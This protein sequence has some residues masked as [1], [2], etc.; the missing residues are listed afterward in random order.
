MSEKLSTI[1]SEIIQAAS[2]LE[3]DV[4]DLTRDEYLASSAREV[5]S[6]RQII[7]NGGWREL[8][9]LAVDA[10]DEAD[11]DETFY[12]TDEVPE[13]ETYVITWAQNA[14][15]ICPTTLGILEKYCEHNNAKL[16][17][18]PGRYK[19]TLSKDDYWWDEKLVP[20]L[21]KGRLKIGEHCVAYGDISIQPT[22][23]TPL[24]GF[25]VFAGAASAV[26]GH[27]KLQLQTVAS[28]DRMA[29]IFTTTGA[30]TKKN[31]REAKAGAKAAEHHIF[32]AAIVETDGD[33]FHLRQLVVDKNGE[34]YDLDKVYTPDGVRDAEAAAVFVPGD[35]HV[36][37]MTEENKKSLSDIIDFFEPEHMVVHDVLDF[38]VRNHHRR[39]DLID[40]IKRA[41]G[42]KC[43]LVEE[44]VLETCAYLYDLSK[45]VSKLHV[46]RSNHDE[47][48][49]RWLNETWP[50]QDPFNA[51]FWFKT[52]AAMSEE[53][54]Q[55][56]T[57]NPFEYWF[58]EW[59]WQDCSNVHFLE[60]NESLKIKNIAFNFHGDKG[61][62][63]ARGS[64]NQFSKLGT[65]SVVGHSHSPGIRDGAWQTGVGGPLDMGYNNL[66]SSWMNTHCI[67]YANG[68]RCLINV[69]AGGRWR[70]KV[71]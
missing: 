8:V 51:P 43:D 60:R 15:E 58:H 46:V 11:E 52:W 39:K 17:V 22:A 70:R 41:N 5:G 55:G 10:I 33:L 35:L 7:N 57:I 14:T 71:R 34:A 42:H 59:D 23:V 24:T 36:E 18:I 56:N 16:M 12:I 63:G 19:N 30:V 28:E 62:N 47:A 65:K 4:T 21:T 67:V 27:P 6:N 66:P 9:T 45:C 49:E 31:Y 64:L 40:R 37:K 20:Y 69:M 1:L 44:E 29:R 54:V 25:E 26:F 2:E 13:A 61:I 38:D 50:M 68:K 53:A 3:K 48:F 32:G